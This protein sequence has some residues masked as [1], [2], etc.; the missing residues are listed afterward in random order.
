MKNATRQT[1]TDSKKD[2][3]TEKQTSGPADSQAGGHK[4]K[5]MGK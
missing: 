4:D 1:Q 5:Q 3:L 2:R